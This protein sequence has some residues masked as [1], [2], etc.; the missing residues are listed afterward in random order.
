[1]TL[2]CNCPKAA[3]ISE[4]P[5]KVCEKEIGQIQKLIF[6]RRFSGGS[7]NQITIATSNPN[8]LAT[9]TPLLAAADSTKVVV[10]PIVEEPATTPGEARQFG[11]GNATPGGV[12]RILGGNPTA[13]TFVVRNCPQEIIAAMK[14]LMCE[15]RVGDLT[16]SVITEKG[17]IVMDSDNGAAPT[18][19]KGF[20]CDS[21]FVGDLAAGGYD[22]PDQNA[23]SFQLKSGWS[24]NAYFV[25]PDDFDPLVDL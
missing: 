5:D 15:S 18:I 19:A 16:V 25:T 9:W 20:P 17:Q 24:D 8:L 13:M 3:A 7:E 12:I 6:Q 2:I 11:G 23:I 4:I 21:L 22:A 14:E 10:S 1:M